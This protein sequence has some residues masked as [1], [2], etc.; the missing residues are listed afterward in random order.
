MKTFFVVEDDTDDQLLV[1]ALFYRDPRFTLA[2]VAGSAEQALER[3]RKTKP[4]IVVLD[5]VLSGA[6][7]GI[8]AAPRF[9]EA[10]P[11]TKIILFTG[12]AELQ[13]KADAEP[14]VDA[15]LLKTEA[16]RLL[17]LA[18]QLTGSRAS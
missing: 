17:T 16:T 14:A 8:D 5:Q 3:A 15:F 18:Q 11:H 4:E 6:L 12:D 1:Q 10:S 9:K 2:E 13:A 7:N